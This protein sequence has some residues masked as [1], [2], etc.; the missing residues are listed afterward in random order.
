MLKHPN[1]KF[2]LTFN[3]QNKKQVRFVKKIMYGKTKSSS[4]LQDTCSRK[5]K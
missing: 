1:T 5:C 3:V 2:L 4:R